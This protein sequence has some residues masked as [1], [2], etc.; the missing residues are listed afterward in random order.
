[1]Q[2]V[3]C[4]KSGYP[5][6]GDLKDWK[7]VFWEDALWTAGWDGLELLHDVWERDG[8]NVKARLRRG[9]R[10]SEL[11]PCPTE[12]HSPGTASELAATN[13]AASTTTAANDGK[14][15]SSHTTGG[16]QNQT[17]SPPRARS[18]IPD[19]HPGLQRLARIY[20]QLCRLDKEPKRVEFESIDRP[21]RK[22]VCTWL[23]PVMIG[24]L[25]CMQ[26][27]GVMGWTWEM[28]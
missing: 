11:A 2:A 1:V 10:E 28:R 4:A 5:E 3:I 27:S 12:D 9:K 13:T 26:W 16:G 21:Q 17:V 20:A 18:Q 24:D 25:R 22:K 23:G 7:Q 6:F 8:R 19:D 15:H 14:V